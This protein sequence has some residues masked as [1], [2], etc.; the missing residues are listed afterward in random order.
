MSRKLSDNSTPK[1]KSASTL[2]TGKYNSLLS[3]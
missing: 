1:D 2:I 3:E